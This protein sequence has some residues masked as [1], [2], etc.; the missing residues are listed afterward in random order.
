M[1]PSLSGL[2]VGLT[3]GIGSG[4]STVSALFAQ[5]GAG[6]VQA[7]A[8]A[9]ELTAAGGAAIAAIESTFGATFITPNGALDR[10]RMRAHVFRQPRE[11][12]RLEALLHPLIQ[13]ACVAQGAALSAAG[14]PYL[15]FDIPLLAES[16]HWRRDLDRILVIDCT[17]A[18]QVVRVVANRGLDADTVY[19]IIAQQAT[20][21][22]RLA[23]A[24]EVLVNQMQ[25]ADLT[26]RVAQ[27]H[28][29]YLG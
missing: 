2:R 9:H 11:R 27:L 22:Q 1:D 26:A 28:A 21:A 10:A 17:E 18:L 19:A 4:K 12:A 25:T 20:R 15:V 8:I 14:A 6:V 13:Q 5:L 16:A 23:I 29:H 3:G 7:D 24:T